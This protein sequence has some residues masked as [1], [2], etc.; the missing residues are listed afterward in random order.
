LGEGK[1]LIKVFVSD[2]I[3]DL[4][5]RVIAVVMASGE[6]KR[7]KE[8]S[9]ND[10]KPLVKI[11]RRTVLE[12]VIAGLRGHN[13]KDIYLSVGYK[14]QAIKE[15][16]NGMSASAPITE[17]QRMEPIVRGTIMKTFSVFVSML[18]LSIIASLLIESYKKAARRKM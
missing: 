6:G 18:L 16:E 1:K 5:Q 14:A 13:V 3:G 8:V 7:L 4:R 10:P 2:M 11:E 12:D 17:K 15:I 9:R